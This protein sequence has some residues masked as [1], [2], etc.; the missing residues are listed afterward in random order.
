MKTLTALLAATVWLVSTS[1]A[2]ARQKL[3][4]HLDICDVVRFH[5]QAKSEEYRALLAKVESTPSHIAA[6]NALAKVSENLMNRMA[7]SPDLMAV[8]VPSVNL[9]N[10][11]RSSDELRDLW[12]IVSDRCLNT[13]RQTP[14][15]VTQNLRAY[16]EALR[17]VAALP[18]A[19]FDKAL[20]AE[21]HAMAQAFGTPADWRRTLTQVL[22]IQGQN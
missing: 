7:R 5:D 13:V 21:A 1:E 14:E 16:T 3:P 11:G 6:R 22:S 9:I 12:A 20:R 2:S 15:K 4:A 8:Y 10:D 18:D 19:D 17:A